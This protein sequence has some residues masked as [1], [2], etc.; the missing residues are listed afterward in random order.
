MG[1]WTPPI[2][3]EGDSET[4]YLVADDFGDLGQSWRETDI[5]QT[6]LETVILNL[7]KGEYS[8][9]VRVI[10]FNTDE[11][12]V[13]GCLRR[14][15][16]RIAVPLRPPRADRPDTVVARSACR[17]AG[18]GRVKRIR[19]HLSEPRK[20]RHYQP[21]SSTFALSYSIP[22]FCKS[23]KISSSKDVVW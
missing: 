6:D 22:C 12:W 1:N 21:V 23:A 11:G 7:L 10:G 2:V 8:N 18:K 9:P 5:G 4:V 15:R 17:Q 19:L 16:Q 20:G 14:C 13:S 3:P